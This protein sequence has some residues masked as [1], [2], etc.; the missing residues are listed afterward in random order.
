MHRLGVDA[1]LPRVGRG[2]RLRLLVVG[3]KQQVLPRIAKRC[4][5]ACGVI[6]ELLEYQV[7]ADEDINELAHAPGADPQ[8]AAVKAGAKVLAVQYGGADLS[9]R[10]PDLLKLAVF[11]AR[12]WMEQE[13]ATGVQTGY[14]V[15]D[16]ML[17]GNGLQPGTLTIIAE[18]PS[19]GKSVMSWCIAEHAAAQHC[20][21]YFSLESSRRELGTRAL[22]WHQSLLDSTDEAVIHLSA[23]NL[24]IDD[25]PAIGLAHMRIR[26]RRIR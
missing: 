23:L 4:G 24:M 7:D 13:H 26:L 20:V 9:T 22:R 10:D 1:S 8:E 17:P 21:A 6:R 18:R 2:C 16:G 12:D 5:R 15:L 14:S 25:T 11:E 3:P 19:M